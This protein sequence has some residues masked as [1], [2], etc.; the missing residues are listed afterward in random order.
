MSAGDTQ[1]MDQ[2]RCTEVDPELFFIDVGNAAAPKSVC[3]ECEVRQ[4]CLDW[5][6]D[7]NQQY[8]IWGGMGL[9]DRRRYK[10]QRA[11]AAA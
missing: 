10:R 6:V 1:W 3:K 2:G 4:V 7:T 5:A 8:G 9:Q 11:K